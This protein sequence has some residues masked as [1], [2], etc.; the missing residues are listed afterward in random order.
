VQKNANLYTLKRYKFTKFIYK[1]KIYKAYFQ[2]ICTVKE[3]YLV[4][5]IKR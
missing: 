3:I 4:L 1:Y 5:H 2:H